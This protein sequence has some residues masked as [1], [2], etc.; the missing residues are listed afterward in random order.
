MKVLITGAAGQLGHTLKATA[1][2]TITLHAVD[3]GDCDLADSDA[4]AA[5]VRDVAP[6]III[7]AAAYTAVD[8]AESDEESARAINTD[9]VAALVAAHCG[10][11][12]HVSTDFVFDGTSSRAYRPDHARN[13]LSA[14]GRT[15]AEGEDHLR[16]TDLLVRSS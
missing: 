14:Y 5:L 10:K 9:A 4:I 6:D 16:N 12:V 15:K 3:K 13:P 11:L 1:P 2:D 7:N 8:M